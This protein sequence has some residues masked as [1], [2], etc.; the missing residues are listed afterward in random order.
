MLRNASFEAISKASV[1]AQEL[2]HE[3]LMSMYSIVMRM[4]DV[5]LERIWEKCDYLEQLVDIGSGVT[6]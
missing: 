5:Q 2:A 1:K 4:C 3:R 6:E